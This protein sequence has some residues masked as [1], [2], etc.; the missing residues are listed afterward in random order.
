MDQ[1]PIF[2]YDALVEQALRGVVREALSRAAEHGLPGDHHFYITFRTD[3]EGVS[4]P[5]HLAATHPED[6]TIVLQHEFWDLS[7]DTDAPDTFGVTLSFND[8]KERLVVPFAAITGFADPSA[9]FGLQF[10]Y[11]D[12]FEDSLDDDP[13]LDAPPPN[14]LEI[15]GLP[16]HV[17]ADEPLP[18]DN[19]KV[20]VLDA[21]RK[22]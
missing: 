21:F 10:Q 8:R 20:V 5:S 9:K 18:P 15:P 11:E 22:K 7:V 4:I 19:S 6:I 17:R 1:R 14:E 3:A 2:D 16:R 13:L 12:D